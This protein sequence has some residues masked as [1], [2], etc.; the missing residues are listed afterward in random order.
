VAQDE[1]EQHEVRK[2]KEAGNLFTSAR[3]VRHSQASTF[4][5]APRIST[6]PAFSNPLQGPRDALLKKREPAGVLGLRPALAPQPDDQCVTLWRNHIVVVIARPDAFAGVVHGARVQLAP[7]TRWCAKR[8]TERPDLATVYQAW[9]TNSM[10]GPVYP[11]W[12]QTG[13]CAAIK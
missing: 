9:Y 8:P 1:V 7:R 2:V 6:E 11:A 12:L 3:I 13:S 5:S 10:V 4:S